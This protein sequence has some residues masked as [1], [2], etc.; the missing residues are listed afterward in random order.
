M[1]KKGH[2]TNVTEATR[3]ADSV[4][5]Q[6]GRVSR[7]DKRGTATQPK[8]GQEWEHASTPGMQRDQASLQHQR[9][10][11]HLMPRLQMKVRKLL[12]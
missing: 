1:I 4:R 8:R 9:T 10:L 7:F 11:L 5:V 2:E 12:A 3:G 6:R